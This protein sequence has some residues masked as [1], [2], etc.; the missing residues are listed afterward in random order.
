MWYSMPKLSVLVYAQSI[1]YADIKWIETLI[2]SYSSM[3]S[4]ESDIEDGLHWMRRESINVVIY[5]C[6]VNTEGIKFYIS[7]VCIFLEWFDG[8]FGITVI[9]RP[10]AIV[11]RR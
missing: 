9:T 3:H 7:L 10:K 5:C 8:I 11:V 2:L 1:L 4:V 6:D